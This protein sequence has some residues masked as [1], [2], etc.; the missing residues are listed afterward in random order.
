MVGQASNTS[1]GRPSGGNPLD[2]QAASAG[3]FRPLEVI[4]VDDF[5]TK[6]L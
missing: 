2:A 4:T 6:D 3:P 5:F 1:L